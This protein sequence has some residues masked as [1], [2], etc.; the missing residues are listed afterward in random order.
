M[1]EISQSAS[2][3]AIPQSIT[4]SDRPTAQNIATQPFQREELTLKSNYDG[5]NLGVS[6][7]V[8]NTPKGIIQL[9]HGMAE[10]RERYHDFMD[11]L[12]RHGYTVIIHDHRGHG[13]S[14]ASKD[15]YGY[16]GP[17]SQ[18]HH[19]YDVSNPDHS[20]D[21]AAGIISDVHQITDYIKQRF[22]G[23][24]LTLFG[25]SMGSLVVRCYMQQY[26]QDI[27]RLIVCGSP[28]KNIGAGPAITIAKLMKLFR[29]ERHRS[30]LINHLAFGG[31]NKL[32]AKLAKSNNNL[33]ATYDSGPNAW[34]V[35]DPAVVAAYDAD[36]R[37]GFTFTLNGFIVLFSLM[38]RA[39]NP[40]GWQMKN[41]AAPILFIAGAD[42]PCIISHKDFAKAVDFMRARGYTDVT[43]KLYPKM[44]HEILNERGKLEVWTDIL[45]WIETH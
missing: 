17:Y 40:K 1:N 24:P 11:F 5:L 37:D 27:N 44:R 3:N 38:K 4:P 10:H 25:H 23:L 36:E 28:S 20:S 6:L 2:K 34:V 30:K 15:D 32:S 8:P 18:S 29:G 33:D 43:S 19:G 31:Y 16:F 13:A 42:D 26:D 9:V 21:P 39:Y 22:P 41:P 14:V 45:S 35:S 12:A 7:R